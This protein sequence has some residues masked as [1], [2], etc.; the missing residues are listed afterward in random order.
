VGIAGPIVDRTRVTITN[1]DPN[2][3]DIQMSELDPFAF[4]PAH[5]IFINDLEGTCGGIQALNEKDKLCKYYT[6]LWNPTSPNPVIPGHKSSLVLAMGTG[7]GTALIVTDFTRKSHYILPMEAGHIYV[8]PLGNGHEHHNR[9]NE[10]VAFVSEMLYQNQHSIEFEDICSGRGISYVYKW[11]TGE[12][13]ETSA[14]VRKAHSEN[15]EKS[16][17]SLKYVYRTLMRDAQNLCVLS[18]AKSVFLSGD[19]QVSNLRFVESV[20]EDLRAEFLNHVK[21][22]WLEEIDVWTQTEEANFN[23]FGAFY[24]IKKFLN[25]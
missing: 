12:S 24:L 4:P 17:L 7:L 21:R 16:L 22:E 13:L 11:L 20:K 18:Q 1:Y 23:L 5:S 3:R 15:D 19:N 8:T 2:D 9:D 14:I 10:L 25:Q 6:S